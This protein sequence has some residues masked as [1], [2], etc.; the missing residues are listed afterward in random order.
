TEFTALPADDESDVKITATGGSIDSPMLEDTIDIDAGQA[1]D[2]IALNN[3]DDLELATNEV[4]LS[5]VPV[6]QARIRVIGASENAPDFDVEIT[7]GPKLF[8]G[9]GFKDSSDSAVVDAST[10][11]IQF[12]DGDDVLAR[13]EGFETAANTSYDLVLIGNAD[14]GTLQVIALSAPTAAIEGVNATPES[15][16]G[17]GGAALAETATPE[18]LSTP[19]S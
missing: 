12:K 5:P 7:D 1:Y 4:D 11:D 13:V 19:G 3:A 15:T 10:Y 18:V 14:D 17:T 16:P 2:V 8:D 9:I 6:D